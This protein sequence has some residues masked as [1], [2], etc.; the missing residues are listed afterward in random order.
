MAWNR[1][2]PQNTTKIRDLGTVLRPNFQAIDSAD[3]S[4][5]PIAL[6]LSDRDTDPLS[7]S[8]DPTA[9]AD[10]YLLYCKQD[11]TGAAEFFGID[12]NS[13]ISQFTSTDQTL[14]QSGHAL[15]PPGILMNWGRA[16]ILNGGTTVSIV[17]TRAYSATPWVINVTPYANLTPGGGANSRELGA[18][19][20]STTGFDCVCFNGTVLQNVEIGFMAIGPA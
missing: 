13:V 14:A 5:K 1:D 3:S 2:E 9:I 12:A 19:N 17:F 11:S 7:P 10:A 15:L 6:N 8:S 4:F 18:N 20:F 16:T